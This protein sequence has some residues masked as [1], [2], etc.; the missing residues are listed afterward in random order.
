MAEPISAIT[1][2]TT[3]VKA[4]TTSVTTAQKISDYV[5][6]Y[7]IA[8]IQIV[9]MKAECSAVLTALLELQ[10][11]II[12]NDIL[13]RP[14]GGPENRTL[15]YV[16]ADYRGIL[17]QCF[18]IFALLNERLE[19]LNVQ[20]LNKM[21]QSKAKGKIRAIW[22]GDSMMTLR[23]NIKGQVSAINLLL[24][25]FQ[26]YGAPIPRSPFR[27]IDILTC[28]H[29]A[30]NARITDS[31]AANTEAIA[32]NS[33]KL[34]QIF[35]ILTQRDN[36]VLLRR[37]ADDARSL[38]S[39]PLVRMVIEHNEDA[40]SVFEGQ[41]SVLEDRPGNRDLYQRSN[42]VRD[43]ARR[44]KGK[45]KMIEGQLPDTETSGSSAATNERDSDRFSFVTA[46]SK[47]IPSIRS[48]LGTSNE[49]VQ[50]NGSANST[51]YGASTLRRAPHSPAQIRMQPTVNPVQTPHGYEVSDGA[52]TGGSMDELQD[53]QK[54]RWEYLMNLSP[55]QVILDQ[56][57]D[58]YEETER[59]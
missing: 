27:C 40:Q 50:S 53:E 25:A 43:Q 47:I 6:R 10:N 21:G 45:G 23:D 35:R 4:V 19:K 51:L 31:L 48:I 42:R 12:Q 33:Q 9:A 17:E 59:G 41:A 11:I 38:S 18:I 56:T 37:V 1:I 3:V 57:I 28:P 39:S 32:N 30:S 8:E 20:Q 52:T 36:A 26:T 29:S 49:S 44:D 7:K 46:R 14:T 58:E 13:Q 24:A 55:H 16:Q 15:A 22:F 2:I 54:A 5:S 34:E